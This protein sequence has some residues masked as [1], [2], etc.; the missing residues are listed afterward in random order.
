MSSPSTHPHPQTRMEMKGCGTNTSSTDQTPDICP[1][2][3]QRSPPPLHRHITNSP[4][5]PSAITASTLTAGPECAQTRNRAHRTCPKRRQ[6]KPISRRPPKPFPQPQ[7]RYPQKAKQKQSKKP[8]RRKTATKAR[9]QR[10]LPPPTEQ[11]LKKQETTPRHHQPQKRSPLL[12][13]TNDMHHPIPHVVVP[14][15]D[16]RR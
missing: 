11:K 4:P 1:V 6:D 9:K 3:R 7:G 15:R 14:C 5:Q 13:E 2:P 10:A 12:A 8:R 16:V